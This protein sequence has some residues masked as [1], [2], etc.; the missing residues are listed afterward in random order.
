MARKLNRSL[1]RPAD[2][3]KSKPDSSSDETEAELD[4][5]VPNSFK[6]ATGAGS[7]W[8]AGAVAQ[9]QGGLDQAREQIARDILSGNKVVELDPHQ[10]EDIIGTDR[11]SDWKERPEFAEFVRS[12]EKHGQDLPILVWPKDPDW[13]P[14]ELDPENL[15]RVQFYLLAGRRRTEAT[16]RLGRKVRAVIA[17]QNTRNSSNSLFEM[18]S[19]RFRENEE[20]E[21]LSAFERL[22][23]I[24]EMYEALNE[25]SNGKLKAKDFAEQVDV[26]ESVVS[27]AK[28]ALAHKDE[29]L[30]AFKKVYD[31]SYHE[32]QKVLQQISDKPVTAKGSKPKKL[33]V[34]KKVGS[35][36]LKLETS[37]GK[38]AISTS[39]VKLDKK[40]LDQ[41]GELIAKYLEETKD[42]TTNP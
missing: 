14:D 39:G 26:H 20:R 1:V 17:P 3:G 29:I 31:M 4:S 10:I 22:L 35:R 16:N 21:D 13:S 11:R 32:I 24:G 38:L 15:E 19:L 18:L 37:D 23:S 2:V 33:R 28:K 5:S 27:R 12:I 8:K 25:T 36:N 42:P 6:R 7:A 30:N 34:T 41:L 40:Q 9:A